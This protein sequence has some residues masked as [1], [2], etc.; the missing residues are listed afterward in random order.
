MTKLIATFDI[1][2]TS[3]KV[4]LFSHSLKQ[5]TCYV[6]EYSLNTNGSLVEADPSIYKEAI[7]IGL[8][9]CREAIP[10]SV[11]TAIGIT[12]Q[13]ETLIPVDKS[14]RPLYPA[15]VWL[16]SRAKEQALQL[17]EKFSLDYFYRNTGLPDISGSLPIAKLMWFQQELPQIYANTYKF[18]L[19]EDYIL[20]W[21]TGCFVTEKTLLTSTGYF[22]IITDDYWE[23][24]LNVAG[25]DL[26]KL[27]KVLE[28]GSMVGTLTQEAADQI[29]LSTDTFVVT[30]AMDQIASA[31]AVGC[32]S[33]GVIT[34]TTGTA[35]VVAACT[36][37]P[38]FAQDHR[39]TIYRH[40]LPGRFLYLPIGNTAGMA[41]KWFKDE[42]CKDLSNDNNIYPILDELVNTI[43][44]GSE[45]LLFLP[46]LC[47]SVD[48]ENNPHAKGVFFGAQ[49]GT[50]RN[51][52]IRSIL[53]SIGYQ[54]KDFLILCERL[55]C[56]PKKIYSLG[57][58]SRSE[59]WQQIKA[60]CTGEP[61][62][63]LEINEASSAGA[64][65]LAAWGTGIC[66]RGKLPPFQVMK[67]YHPNPQLR[68]VYQSQYNKYCRLYQAVKPYF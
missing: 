52:F 1:G 20:Y 9:K 29:N 68:E 13:G 65:L 58:G 18:L 60:D 34:E 50:H 31:L 36:N 44:P 21:L 49:L 38:V 32:I 55:G 3:V 51:H 5:V 67:C 43:P 4:S 33:P 63:V 48:P 56:K 35:L 30:G 12:T 17:K 15:I 45:G 66:E 2:T 41:L 8:N 25:I 59:T 16:D 7:I 37:T 22:N 46:Y 57:G 6:K 10:D 53:E 28:A 62:T 54:L 24:S 23:E 26:I 27:P 40:A 61:L 19:L 42:F 14:G 64:A 11:I 47:G 39:V